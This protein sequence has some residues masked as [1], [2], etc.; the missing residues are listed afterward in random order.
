MK[1]HHR[2]TVAKERPLANAETLFA[3]ASTG[4]LAGWALLAVAVFRRSRAPLVMAARLV[5]ALLAGLYVAL[6]ARGIA[7]GPGLP[8][9]AGFSTLAGVEALFTRR[10][11]ILG[12]WIHF[13]AFDLFVGT[14]EAEDAGRR[15]MPGWLLL[16]CLFLTL[17]A[18]PA[19]L[20]LYLLLALLWRVRR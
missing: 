19:G 14:W 8:E 11:A 9:G 17:M 3:L 1:R 5:A 6:L 18:G 13:L 10:E 7:L 4:A 2:P 12:G 20:L 16:P 15:N